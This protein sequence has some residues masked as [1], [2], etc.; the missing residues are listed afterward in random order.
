MSNL[1]QTK[2]EVNKFCKKKKF[3]FH[4]MEER[5]LSIISS[6]EESQF[7]E[8]LDFLF[9]IFHQEFPNLKNENGSIMGFD[10]EFSNERVA[11]IQLSTNLLC[12]IFQVS[13]LNSLP[14]SLVDYLVS[15][16]H[17][18]CGV[19]ISGGSGQGDDHVLKKTFNIKMNGCFDIGEV[20]L[21]K[22]ITNSLIY[23]LVF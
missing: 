7:E 8:I 11:T 1:K 10:L 3:N 17:F 20:A 4:H 13:H 22:G 15:E 19:G 14:K 18:K 12:V 9:K 16:E 6:C 23:F 21:K 2:S 5:N